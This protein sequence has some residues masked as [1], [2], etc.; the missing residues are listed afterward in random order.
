M[1]YIITA[2]ICTLILS[3][4]LYNIQINKQESIE[5]QKQM[6]IDQ[7]DKE[8]DA[9]QTEKE[10]N[11]ILLDA[12]LYDA[13]TASFE[14]LKLNWTLQDDGSVRSTYIVSDK[15]QK[16]KDLAVD[17]CFKKYK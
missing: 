11:Q 14:Y 3:V 5:A 17:I 7:K 13:D 4:S 16:I 10:N 9:I 6:E 15:A 1:K 8:L 2:I 12:C